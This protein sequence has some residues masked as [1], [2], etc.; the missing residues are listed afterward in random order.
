M[1]I[2]TLSRHFSKYQPLKEDLRLIWSSLSSSEA[3][4]LLCSTFL[5]ELVQK[6]HDRCLMFIETALEIEM[7]PFTQN[8][9]YLETASSKWLAR[10]K[11]ARAL[12]TESAF[13]P[14]NGEQEATVPN[15]EGGSSAPRRSGR[16]QRR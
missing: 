5:M 8:V 3:H 10:Y 2:T 16:H 14:L 7:T 4:D 6:H 15:Q 9:H 11:D 12:K 1:L 13:T